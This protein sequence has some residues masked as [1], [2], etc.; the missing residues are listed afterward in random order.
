MQHVICSVQSSFVYYLS[1]RMIGTTVLQTVQLSD[2]MV[3]S[4]IYKIT[5]SSVVIFLHETLQS[6]KMS[7]IIIIIYSRPEAHTTKY[8]YQGAAY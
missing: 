6:C 2:R 8:N 5:I 7:L 4:Q 3:L 1:E